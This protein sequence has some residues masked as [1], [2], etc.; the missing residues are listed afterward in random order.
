MAIRKLCVREHVRVQLLVQVDKWWNQM[1]MGLKCKCINSVQHKLQPSL[2]PRPP[3]STLGFG[4]ETVETSYHL[5]S[6]PDPPLSTLGFG[7][8]TVESS[9]NLVSYPDPPFQPWG[10]G[11]RLAT[12]LSWPTVS[13]NWLVKIIWF[14]TTTGQMTANIQF[15]AFICCLYGSNTMTVFAV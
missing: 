11:M 10:L 8:E 4:Y 3:L 15:P 7:Y 6:Y 13:A 5:V 2:V 9:Y 12:T 1:D 14:H